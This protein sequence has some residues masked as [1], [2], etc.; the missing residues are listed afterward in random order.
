MLKSIH[1]LL[2]PEDVGLIPSTGGLQSA[3]TSVLGSDSF[4]WPP[5]APGTQLVHIHAHTWA[6]DPPT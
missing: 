3:A 2:L 5:W 4:F 6:K 1:C